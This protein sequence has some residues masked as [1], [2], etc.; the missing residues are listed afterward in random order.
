MSILTKTYF[1]LGGLL[2]TISKFPM[3]SWQ[4]FLAMVC[5]VILLTM[6]SVGIEEYYEQVQMK[7]YIKMLRKTGYDKE[8]DKLEKLLPIK[9][10][11]IEKLKDMEDDES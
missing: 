10:S 7:E 1:L 8:A 5:L 3:F 9:K 11:F 2:A 6:Y 4:N